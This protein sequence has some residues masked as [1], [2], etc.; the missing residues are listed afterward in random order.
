MAPVGRHRYSSSA[1]LY[2]EGGHEQAS[3]RYSLQRLDAIDDEAR[4]SSDDA[5]LDGDD[6]HTQPWTT[7]YSDF[8]RS[9]SAQRLS[10]LPPRPPVDASASTKTLDAFVEQP[11]LDKEDWKPGEAQRELHHKRRQLQHDAVDATRAASSWFGRH[12]R[13]LAIGLVVVC[14]VLGVVLGVCLPRA[15]S[16][17]F[18][19]LA[20]GSPLYETDSSPF[21]SQAYGN[22]SFKSDLFISIDAKSSI[23]PV[24]FKSFQV[25]VRRLET[26]VV[27]ARGPR[28]GFSVAGRKENVYAVPLAWSGLFGNASDPDF[29]AIYSAC[30]PIYPTTTRSLLNLT[31]SAKF[32]M[33]GRIGTFKSA[34]QTIQGVPCPVEFSGTAS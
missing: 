29:E 13:K 24:N 6:E 28:T 1:D 25:E 18:A 15:P 16:V 34:Q 12:W 7:S 33:V 5:R 22:F 21:V 4:R 14:A 32:E 2:A 20:T 3:S 27:L 10:M 31:M 30:G 23:V 19:N 11:I 26:N 9:D 8:R 17:N